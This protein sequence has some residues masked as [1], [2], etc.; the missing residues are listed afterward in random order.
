MNTMISEPRNTVSK[1]SPAGMV[2]IPAGEFDMGSDEN[3]P[4]SPIHTVSLAAFYM[5]EVPVVNSRFAFFVADT[6]FETSARAE[7][8]STWRTFAT[9]DRQ[10]HPVVLVSWDD[11]VAYATWAGKRLPTEAEWEKAARGL[12]IGALFPW[13]NQRADRG[14]TNWNRSPA[15]SSFPPTTPVRQFP[16]NGYG[17]HEMAG[18]VW[19]W[20][21]DWYLE[22]YYWRSPSRDPQGP[23]NG[24]TRVRR[25]AAW[26]VRRDFRL[27]CSTR[28]NMHPH[29]GH[30]NLGFRC[31]RSVAL[32]S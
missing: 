20:C 3:Q 28:G 17:L 22:D 9:P 27:R 10:D 19:E 1:T 7:D 2:L 4:E 31:V 29:K 8:G 16:A 30:P 6:G 23:D 26:N 21:N 18:N 5:D 24:N 25:G 15:E 11:A 32:E 12:L 14:H 13:G